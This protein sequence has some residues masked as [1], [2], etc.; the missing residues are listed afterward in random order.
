MAPFFCATWALSFFFHA[1]LRVK[2]MPKRRHQANRLE[3]PAGTA[4]A[5]PR[6][7]HA[8][9]LVSRAPPPGNW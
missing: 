6:R 9:W 8:S 3:W 4:T 1:R 7:T 2:V 5:D